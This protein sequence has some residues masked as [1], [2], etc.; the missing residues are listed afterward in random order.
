MDNEKMQYFTAR[1]TQANR[2]QLIVIMFEIMI[3]AMKTAKEYYVQ[4]DLVSCEKE[5]KRGQ[6]ILNRLMGSLDFQY[7]ISLELWNLYE[8]VNRNISVALAKRDPTGLSTSISLMSKLLVGFEGVEKTDQSGPLME[9]TQK[10]YAGLTYGRGSLNEMP[11]SQN[12]W[13]RA[14]FKKGQV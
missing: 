1:I 3:D 10:L 2:T 14:L 13:G 7:G 4:E 6:K 8:Y 11:V 9:N 12:D 5:L